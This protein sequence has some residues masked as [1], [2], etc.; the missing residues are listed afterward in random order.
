[1]CVCDSTHTHSSSL[2]SYHTLL[3]GKI[4]IKD[5]ISSAIL[6]E[7]LELRNENWSAGDDASNWFSGANALRVYSQ[8]RVGVCAQAA[9]MM[10]VGVWVALTN[11]G[12]TRSTWTWTLITMA[13]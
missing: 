2:T 3:P 4:S 11:H 12:H 13:C 6:G 10:A 9:V 8:V 1:M 7:L 5:L